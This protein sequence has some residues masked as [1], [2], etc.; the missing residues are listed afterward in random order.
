MQSSYEAGAKYIVVFNYAENMTGPFGILKDEHFN[1]L[2]RF[3]NNVVQDQGTKQGSTKAEAVLVLPH[4][5]G[6]GMRHQQDN[7]WGLW[8]PDEKSPQIWST[9]Q[10]L[11]ARYDTKLDIVYDDEAFSIATKYSQV[12]YWNQSS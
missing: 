12:Y 3:W 4:N 1:A 7:I 8:Q 2:R 6:W 9:L 5:Y 10:S 11:L